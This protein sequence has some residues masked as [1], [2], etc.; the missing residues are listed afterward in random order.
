MPE[1][2]RFYGMVITFNW[3]E[4]PPRHFHVRY[5]EWEATIRLDTMELD[6]GDLPR[7][8]LALVLEWA[9]LHREELEENW[10]RAQSRQAPLPIQPLS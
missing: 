2:A 5:A 8:A 3:R 7:R 1:I 10:R 9:T 6:T 4:H